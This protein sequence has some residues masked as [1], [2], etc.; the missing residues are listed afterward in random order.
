MVCLQSVFEGYEKRLEVSF[1]EPSIFQDSKGP[2]IIQTCGNHQAPPI[3]IRLFLSWPV[4][5]SECR[6]LKYTRGLLRPWKRHPFSSPDF[7]R[8][9]SLF[10]DCT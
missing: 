2:V 6:V 5:L 1:F 7:S 9:M 10:F 3:S 4:T 8:E